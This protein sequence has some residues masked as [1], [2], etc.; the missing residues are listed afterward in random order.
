[1]CQQYTVTVVAT[2]TTTMNANTCANAWVARHDLWNVIWLPIV[3]MTNLYVLYLNPNADELPFV[4]VFVIYLILDFIYIFVKP[5]SVSNPKVILLHHIVSIVGACLIPMAN[6]E[7]KRAICTATLVEINT[8][9]R[10]LKRFLQEYTLYLDILFLIS[11]AIIRLYL[12]PYVQ[13]LLAK[14]CLKSV[15]P[16]NVMLFSMG[17]ILNALSVQ[18]TIDLIKVTKKRYF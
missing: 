4:K 1:M 6:D 2:T 16:I 8:W 12:G 11:W 18:W 10:M 3:F 15:G 14:E 9:F 7:V 17:L 5:E 13:V